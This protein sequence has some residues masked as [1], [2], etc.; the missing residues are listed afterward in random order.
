MFA[1]G[2]GGSSNLPQLGLVTGVVTLDGEPL[3]NATVLFHPID[4]STRGG[5]GKTDAKGAYELMFD[6]NTAGTAIG[7]SRVYIT[8]YSDEAYDESGEK[9]IEEEKSELVRA[10]F[11]DNTTLT[12]KVELGKNVFDFEV[13]RRE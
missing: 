2:C 9:L 11:N 10:D 8:T 12:A 1:S 4:G 6:R 5:A 13:T 7:E 3:A